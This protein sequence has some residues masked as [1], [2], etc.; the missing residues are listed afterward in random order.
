MDSPREL[1][2]PSIFGLVRTSAVSAFP[3][4]YFNILA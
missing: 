2:F 4:P 3:R 1:G